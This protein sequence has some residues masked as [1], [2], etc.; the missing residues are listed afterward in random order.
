MLRQ[1]QLGATSNVEAPRFHSC[2]FPASYLNSAHAS[3]PCCDE[4]EHQ[5]EL[6]EYKHSRPIAHAD[7]DTDTDIDCGPD[8]CDHADENDDV[9]VKRS[10]ISICVK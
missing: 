5:R 4:E 7:A 8:D 9:L 2:S 1:R 3:N 6:L 10:H